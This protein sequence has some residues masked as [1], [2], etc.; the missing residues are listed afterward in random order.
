MLTGKIMKQK[1]P[2]WTAECEI[3][4]AWTQGRSRKEAME[5]LADCIETKINRREIKVTVAALTSGDTFEVAIDTNEPGLLA[6]E[7]LKYQRGVHGLSLADVAKAL[8]S[9]SRNGYASYEQ[10]RR[11]PSL[12]KFRELLSAVAP[13]ITFIIARRAAT[14]AKRR[15][16]G[17]SA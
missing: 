4:G 2:W 5:M 8:G 17:R 7:V 12:S 14:V 6:A 11:E 13:E 15:K 10:G 16:R 3:I 1:T 9:S